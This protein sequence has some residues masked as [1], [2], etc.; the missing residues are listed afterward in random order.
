MYTVKYVYEVTLFEGLI[1]YK[2]VCPLSQGL[3]FKKEIQSRTYLGPSETR[4]RPSSSPRP[5]SPIQGPDQQEGLPRAT[6][7][8]FCLD[9]GWRARR[10]KCTPSGSASRSGKREGW[11][12]APCLRPPELPNRESRLSRTQSFIFFRLC[13]RHHLRKAVFISLPRLLPSSEQHVDSCP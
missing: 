12:G 5:P 3:Q 9:N 10:A 7:Y 13:Y 1:Q 4:R 8:K 6:L 11:M 2:T